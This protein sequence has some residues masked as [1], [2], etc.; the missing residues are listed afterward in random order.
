MPTL[1]VRFAAADIQPVRL[2]GPSICTRLIQIFSALPSLNTILGATVALIA[3][4]WPSCSTMQLAVCGGSQNL[5]LLPLVTAATI[6][7]RLTLSSIEQRA[8][9]KPHARSRWSASLMVDLAQVLVSVHLR[10]SPAA[11]FCCSMRQRRSSQASSAWASP[12]CSSRASAGCDDSTL[13]S[14]VAVRSAHLA[15]AGADL[16]M[17]SWASLAPNLTQKLLPCPC[18]ESEARDGVRPP[19]HR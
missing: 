11:V 14:R 19:A 17:S 9:P 7:A 10:S 4:S 1:S 3:F 2:P 15:T 5:K 6:E 18:A 13:A 12:F 8:S 16:R